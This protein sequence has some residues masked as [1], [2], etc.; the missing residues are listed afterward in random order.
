MDLEGRPIQESRHSLYISNQLTL[1]Y[2][3][4]KYDIVI[5]TYQT[6]SSELT[7]QFDA[8]IGLVDDGDADDP[9]EMPARR[10]KEKRFIPAEPDSVLTK[11]A[12][13]RIILDEAH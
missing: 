8:L 3:L 5:T 10:T 4:A 12:W 1:P 7:E 6:V 9:D 2:R 13:E 11:I